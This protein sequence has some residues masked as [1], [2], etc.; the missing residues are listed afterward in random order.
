MERGRRWA[1]T[2]HLQRLGTRR[3]GVQ[4]PALGALQVR[5]RRIGVGARISSTRTAQRERLPANIDNRAVETAVL[6]LENPETRDPAGE[7]LGFS[8]PV[9]PGDAEQNAQSRSDLPD[10][11]ALDHDP[12][13]RDALDDRAH[14]LEG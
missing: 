3:R 8:L 2:R 1:G 12:R 6:V 4:K 13:R 10:D 5:T 9:L 14:E 11:L 7:A